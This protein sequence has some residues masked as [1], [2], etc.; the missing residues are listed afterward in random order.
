M[1]WYVRQHQITKEPVDRDAAVPASA[2]S[3]RLAV[4]RKHKA[5]ATVSWCAADQRTGASAAYQA[6]DEET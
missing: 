2:D 3:P 1:Q 4:W 6:A 5:K